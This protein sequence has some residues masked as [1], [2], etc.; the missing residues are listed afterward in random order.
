MEEN[1]NTV[2]QNASKLDSD[3]DIKRIWSYQKGQVVMKIDEFTEE[4]LVVVNQFSEDGDKSLTETARCV[5][6]PM[7]SFRGG[8]VTAVHYTC[9]V[10][11]L[12]TENGCVHGF[13]AGG[14]LSQLTRLELR[15]P[16]FKYRHKEAQPVVSISVNKIRNGE[17][18]ILAHFSNSLQVIKK[19]LPFR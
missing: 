17:V 7:V 8:T 14:D 16:D 12:G 6:Q 4:L 10:L 5:Y 3:R 13:A 9:G 11:L 2:Y 1:G 18:L 19:F 15:K